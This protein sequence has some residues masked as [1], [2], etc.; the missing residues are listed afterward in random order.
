MTHMDSLVVLGQVV[1]IAVKGSNLL[2][3]LIVVDKQIILVVDGVLV[4]QIV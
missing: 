2:F 4:N 1:D 3:K